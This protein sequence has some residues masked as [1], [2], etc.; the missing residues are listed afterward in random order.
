MTARQSQRAKKK[1]ERLKHQLGEERFKTEAARR[2]VG[3]AEAELAMRDAGQ[4]TEKAA[5]SAPDTDIAKAAAIS[6]ELEKVR[7]QLQAMRADGDDSDERRALIEEEAAL[8]RLL[9]KLLKR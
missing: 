4:G 7:A 2:K 3:A 1:F 8:E 9:A 6:E 5:P